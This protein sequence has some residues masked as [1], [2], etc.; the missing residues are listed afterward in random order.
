MSI[1]TK[2]ENDIAYEYKEVFKVSKPKKL[3]VLSVIPE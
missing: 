2:N 3:T 1:I